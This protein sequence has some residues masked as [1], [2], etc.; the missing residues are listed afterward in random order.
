MVI[1]LAFGVGS[2]VLAPLTS[3]AAEPAWTSRNRLAA[4]TWRVVD[5]N[6]LDRTFNKQDW[7]KL[8]MGVVKKQYGSDEEVYESLKDMLSK[9]GDRYTRYLP[10]AIHC[11]NE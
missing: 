6:F 8:R 2:N 10:R 7:L 4:E 11:S 9:L 1:S 5:E 3:M